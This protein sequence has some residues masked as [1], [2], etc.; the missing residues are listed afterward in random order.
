MTNRTWPSPAA[1]FGA[2]AFDLDGTI[3]LGDNA[4]PEAVETVTSIRRAGRPVVFVTNKPIY[5]AED[6]AAKLCGIGIPASKSDVVTATDSLISYLHE[7][8]AGATL[9]VVGEP[10]LH[11]TLA[12]AGFGI[13]TSPERA[14]VVAVSFDRTFDYA[15]LEAAYRAVR[16]HGAALVATNPDPFCPTP[17]GGLPDCAAMLAAIEACT[18]SVAEAVTGKPSRQMADAV[19]ARLGVSAEEAAFVGDRLMTDVAMARNAGMRSVLVLT[20]ATSASD[21]KDA[22]DHLRPDYVVTH[23][24]ELLPRMTS[25]GDDVEDLMCRTDARRSRRHG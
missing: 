1:L 19:L 16:L 12:D 6:Y 21:V 15:K 5:T 9:L 18:G 10:L 2:Y 11:R 7:V 20:G 24:G 3:Y 22:Q 8:H 14:D 17:E 23:L 13:T 25:C 4:L